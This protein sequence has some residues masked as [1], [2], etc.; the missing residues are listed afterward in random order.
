[1]R[2]QLERAGSPHSGNLQWYIVRLR[3]P[4]RHAVE[5]QDKRHSIA[6]ALPFSNAMHPTFCARDVLVY[7]LE[8]RNGRCSHFPKSDSV[9]N[10]VLAIYPDINWP[11]DT[12]A[13]ACTLYCS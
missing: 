12:L 10:D 3:G 5:I 11:F 13:A 8:C 2:N 7:L 6:V 1:M 4:S 9:H